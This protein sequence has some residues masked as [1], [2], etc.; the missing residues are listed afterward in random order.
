MTHAGIALDVIGAGLDLIPQ[1]RLRAI[2]A[3]FRPSSLKTE[4]QSCLCSVI[5][6]K[7][8]TTY[9]NV[10][11]DF[12]VRYVDGYSAASFAD[13]VQNAPFAE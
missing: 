13:V 8:E 10:L 9:D 7:P 11:R 6:R 5:R 4:L 12:G 3:E 1:D 2:L